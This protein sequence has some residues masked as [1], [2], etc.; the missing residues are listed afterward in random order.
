[1]IRWIVFDV[2]GVLVD[3]TRLIRGWAEVLG[4]SEVDFTEALRTGIAAGH[5]Y[6]IREGYRRGIQRIPQAFQRLTLIRRDI[7]CE[8]LWMVTKNDRL[9][10]YGDVQAFARRINFILPAQGS[11]S[12]ASFAFLRENDPEGL[13]RAPEGN[14]R[15]VADAT[16]VIR[17][18]AASTDGAVGFFVQFA[19]P[20]NANIRLL[21]EQN[22]R[23]VPV[24][25]REIMRSRVDGEAVYQV[26]EFALTEGGFM[27]IGGRARNATTACT[28]VAIFTGNPDA[29]PAGNARDDQRDLVLRVR[30]MPAAQLLPAQGSIARI[31]SGARR[32][33]QSAVQSMETAAEAAKQAAQRQ[34][35]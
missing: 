31:L 19:D 12:A 33:S 8:G 29:V 16:E 27:G 30:E 26:Q 14:I 4:L 18:V 32:M 25:S 13:G 15:N 2:G 34:L 17:A 3:E 7:A 21:V 20:T 22:L 6:A 1:V 11:G 28:P 35:N 23:T 9:Q 10:S 24:V 5:G